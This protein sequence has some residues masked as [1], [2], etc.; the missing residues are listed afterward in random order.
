MCVVHHCTAITDKDDADEGFGIVPS[1]LALYPH[2]SSFSSSSSSSDSSSTHCAFVCGAG[3]RV[4]RL[5]VELV[6]PSDRKVESGRQGPTIS[7]PLEAVECT[8][9]ALFRTHCAVQSVV[10]TDSCVVSSLA[11]GS[12]YVHRPAVALSSPQ[13]GKRRKLVDESNIATFFQSATPGFSDVQVLP[14]SSSS[15]SLAVS[16]YWDKVVRV[17][18]D[19]QVSSSIHVSRHPNRLTAWS[20]SSLGD[21]LCVCEGNVCSIFD[22]RSNARV[23]QLRPGG[24]ELFACA[25]G[26][27]GNENAVCLGGVDRRA[28]VYDI[29]MGQAMFTYSKLMKYEISSLVTHKHQTG[30]VDLFATGLDHEIMRTP[31]PLLEQA[32]AKPKEKIKGGVKKDHSADNV[33]STWGGVK[34]RGDSRWVGIVSLPDGSVAGLTMNKNLYILESPAYM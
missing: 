31:W 14:S 29:R 9:R 7:R 28:T 10:C 20:N 17:V 27:D 24:G 16:T 12:I 6:A 2:S 18:Q 11:D 3:S 13:S 8:Q 30:A 33:P 23:A 19:C 26:I 15:L 1:R 21:S 32:D 22:V 34:F 5:D 4:D 25:V